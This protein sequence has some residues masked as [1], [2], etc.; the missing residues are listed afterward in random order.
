MALKISLSQG[1][2]HLWAWFHFGIVSGIIRSCGP[3]PQK[4]GEV[5]RFLWRGREE[6]EGEQT[7]DD[8]NWGNITFLDDGRIKGVMQWMGAFEFV[9][10]KVKE[11]D[12][13][14]VKNV[15]SWKEEWRGINDRS[16]EYA[17]VARWGGDRYGDDEGSMSPNSDTDSELDN[18]DS[19]REENEGSEDL[20]SEFP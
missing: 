1:G 9:G 8:T 18:D 15:I 4:V 16:Y 5:C 12:A 13:K 14:W 19:D 6:G 10:K 2:S 3:L 11:P 7:F 20:D 17:R